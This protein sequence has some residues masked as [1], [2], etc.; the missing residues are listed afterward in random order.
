MEGYTGALELTVIALG[1]LLV[2]SFCF[3][4]LTRTLRWLAAFSSRGGEVAGVTY[5][6]PTELEVP[7]APTIGG[8]G[9]IS[10]PMQGRV[11]T[12]RV[13]VGDEVKSG[14]DL[15]MLESWEM[16]Y[17]ISAT[18]DGRVREIFVADGAY[19]KKGEP[20]LAIGE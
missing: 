5:E 14:D 10:S 8:E 19:V 11:L 6:E 15:I 2:I 17:E 4:G 3:V 20:L 7:A 18:S 1:A 12:V 9:T 13:S 16:L